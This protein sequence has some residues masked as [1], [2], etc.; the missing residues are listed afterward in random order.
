MNVCKLHDC[1]V[2][3]DQEFC[4]VCKEGAKHAIYKEELECRIREKNQD[5]ERLQQII[6]KEEGIDEL[7]GELEK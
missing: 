3:H 2:I 6:D 4:P 5:L 7:E 1:L